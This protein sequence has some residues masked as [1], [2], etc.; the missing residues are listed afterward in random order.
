MSF[1]KNSTLT[2]G[3]ISLLSLTTIAAKPSQAAVIDFNSWNS[4]GDVSI[5]G[6]GQVNMSNSSF[7]FGDDT[8]FNPSNPDAYNYTQNNV[9]TEANGS[10]QN[11]VG[12]NNNDLDIN[13]QAFE[14]SAV[15]TTI[16]AL[17]G[18]KLNFKWNFLTNETATSA[19][20]TPL[21][22]FAFVSINGVV[23]KLADFT[24]ASNSSNFFDSETGQNAFSY[25]FAQQGNY[26]VGIGVV[27]IDDYG[28]TSALQVTNAEVEPVPEPLTILGTGVAAGF[29]FMFRRKRS[30]KQ[31]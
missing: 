20:F 1:I 2:A 27:D 28:V 6:S 24:N 12:V 30:K 18:D 5:Q 7:G 15:K 19:P 29:G 3:L 22:D 17:A 16:T 14:G 23:N 21:N 9:S 25:T 26:Q 4:T 11:F 10:L 31:A 8:D 13:G